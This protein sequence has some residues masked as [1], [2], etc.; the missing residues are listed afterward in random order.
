MKNTFTDDHN[1]KCSEIRKLPYGNSGGNML[2]GRVSY[3]KE[4]EYRRGEIKL[5]R[6]YELPSWDSLKI[7]E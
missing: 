3:E 2:V 7:Y 1:R 4:M 5:G 6:A